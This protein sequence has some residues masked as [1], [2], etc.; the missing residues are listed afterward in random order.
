MSPA[1][2]VR[3]ILDSL[4]RQRSNISRSTELLIEELYDRVIKEEN[5]KESSFD[6]LKPLQFIKII[7]NHELPNESFSVV[8][9]KR[10]LFKS[11]DTM[12][13]FYNFNK[14]SSRVWYRL[15]KSDISLLNKSNKTKKYI[16]FTNPSSK[17]YYL[18]DFNDFK[19]QLNKIGYNKDSV[20]VNINTFGHTWV[21]IDWNIE[22]YYSDLSS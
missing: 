9:P 7:F 3:T 5:K 22:K 11:K 12:I 19:N 13:R 14:D 8:K 4:I 6:I 1:E 21:D 18:I 17:Y 16:C 20:E 10:Y 2:L 15:T